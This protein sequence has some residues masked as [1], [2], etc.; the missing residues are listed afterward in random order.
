VDG[1]LE[2]ALSM[3]KA[4]AEGRL[5]HRGLAHAAVST[6]LWLR[7]NRALVDGFPGRTAAAQHRQSAANLASYLLA[8]RF[9][10][11]DNARRW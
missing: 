3:T 9:D 8:T 2:D 7:S 10:P 6:V 4:V 5:K 1:I 11:Y